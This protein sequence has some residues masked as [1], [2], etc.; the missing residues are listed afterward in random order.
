MEGYVKLSRKFFSN[1]L[2]KEA[3]TFNRCEA[4]LDLIQL[5]RYEDEPQ[6]DCV[7]KRTVVYGRGQYPASISFL[8]K[9]WK[10]SYKKVR[11]FLEY[12]TRQEM[13]SIERLQGVNIITL[14]K[15]DE[16]NPRGTI[17]GT[18]EGTIKGTIKGT[19]NEFETNPLDT[20]KGTIEGT[21]RGT[22]RG[23]IRGTNTNKGNNNKETLSKER[24]KKDAALA[25]TL[26]R[27]E[28]FRCSLVPYLERYPVET[29]R[30]FFDYWSEMNKSCTKMRFEQQ[31]TWETPKR[32]ATWARRETIKPNTYGGQNQ[33]APDHRG[34]SSDKQRANAIVLGQALRDF[35]EPDAGMDAEMALPF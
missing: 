31:Q 25:A 2:W 9:R 29:I 35:A 27:K 19:D 3:R 26:S 18:I 16:Y 6:K 33:T 12:L 17:R 24:E 28:D 13:I 21:D 1:D 11:C 14:R 32:L 4:W 5:A 8:S 7:G 15:Y 20:P 22:I 23:T 30:D 34:Y 10:W